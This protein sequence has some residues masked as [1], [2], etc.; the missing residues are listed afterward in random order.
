[1]VPKSGASDFFTERVQPFDLGHVD[2]TF[3]FR[4]KM[5]PIQQM[6]NGP[7]WSSIRVYYIKECY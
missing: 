4:V 5:I 2:L 7:T 1:M 3:I 6:I